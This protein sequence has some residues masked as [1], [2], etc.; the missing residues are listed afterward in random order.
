MGKVGFF[1]ISLFQTGLKPVIEKVFSR[2]IKQPE[3]EADYSYP[4]YVPEGLGSPPGHLYTFTVCCLVQAQ[5]YV[6]AVNCILSWRKDCSV[7]ETD[8][9]ID[10]YF[11]GKG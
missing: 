8:R 4:P 2:M 11:S 10:D 3:R 9:Q 6:L 5:V 1:S 7:I